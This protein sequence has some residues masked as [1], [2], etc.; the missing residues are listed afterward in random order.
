MTESKPSLALADVT[1]IARQAASEQASR[2][3]VLGVSVS[4]DGSNYVEILITSDH[5][6]IGSALVVIGAFR[7]VGE[8]ALLGEIRS[9]LQL[10]QSQ[11]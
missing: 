5:P 3:E 10:Q 11:R 9:R 6:H 2:H 7:D 1:R 4:G 8:A